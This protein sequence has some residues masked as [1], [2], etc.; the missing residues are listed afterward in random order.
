M[1]HKLFFFLFVNTGLNL[2]KVEPSDTSPFFILST[3]RF[4]VVCWR[5]YSWATFQYHAALL[6]TASITSLMLSTN[7]L[8]LVGFLM[9]VRIISIINLSN[10]HRVPQTI[11]IKQGHNGDSRD[12]V[13]CG[14]LIVPVAIS[15]L[16]TPLC[17]S[18]LLHINQQSDL[19]WHWKF[20]HRIS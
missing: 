18:P 17:P 2:S 16:A 15:C 8:P 3:S 10:D 1:F 19:I 4:N 5:P 9:C 12:G 7:Q 13:R 6:G 11:Y 20:Y 14:Y